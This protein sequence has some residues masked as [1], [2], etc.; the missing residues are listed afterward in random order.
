[1]CSKLSE[2]LCGVLK[3]SS[4]SLLSRIFETG[5]YYHYFSRRLRE[6]KSVTQGQRV[7]GFGMGW[8]WQESHPIGADRP[9]DSKALFLSAGEVAFPRGGE[10]CRTGKQESF[11]CMN[12][13][14]SFLHT[15]P[16]VYISKLNPWR[17]DGGGR[18]KK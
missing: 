1:M 14:Q 3:A 5:S 15:P 8:E 11:H 10:Q 4:H 9:E 7:E 18:G 16:P 2:A 6:G 17:K 12:V 13:D